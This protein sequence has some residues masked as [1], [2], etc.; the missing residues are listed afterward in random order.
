MVD[1]VQALV[2]NGIRGAYI[3]SALTPRQQQRALENACAGQYKL[4]YLAPE[5]LNTPSILRLAE[6][7]EISMVV[8]DEAHCVSQWG[9]DFRQ[10][11]LEIPRY[12]N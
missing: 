11:Y 5:R 2:Q 6:C 8:V 9:Q 4:I 12:I 7:V 3:N 10:D 1:Q